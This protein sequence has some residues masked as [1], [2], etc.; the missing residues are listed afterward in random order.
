MNNNLDDFGIYDEQCCVEID[1]GLGSP[2]G[3]KAWL[4][5]LPMVFEYWMERHFLLSGGT[6]WI[7]TADSSSVVCHSCVL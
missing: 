1:L 6:G 4:L 5:A 2:F 3:I 7:T